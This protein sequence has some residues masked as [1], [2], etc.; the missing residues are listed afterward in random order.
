MGVNKRLIGAGAAGGAF[1]NDE[2][3][4]V[5]TYTGNSSTQS[6]T[7]VGFQ[8]DFVWI[9]ERSQ[10][11]NHNLIDS[12]RGTSKILSSNL[13]GGQFTSARFT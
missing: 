6:I 9:K 7:G 11:E 3:F 1:V 5:V 10:A 12:S 13:T 4:R 8:P 2:N